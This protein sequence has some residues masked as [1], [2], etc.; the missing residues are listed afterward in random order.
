MGQAVNYWESW[1]VSTPAGAAGMSSNA[2]LP[3][4]NVNAN[5]NL[6]VN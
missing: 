5:V 1:V 2:T 6:K 3:G 4:Q